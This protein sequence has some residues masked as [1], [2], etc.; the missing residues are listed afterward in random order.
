MKQRGF[1]LLEVLVAMLILSIGLVGLAG[2]MMTGSKNNQSAYH[3][4]QASW[5]AYDI[6]DRMRANRPLAQSGGYD[7]G[8][9]ATPTAT[10]TALTDITQWTTQV[11]NALPEGKGA[12][13]RSNGITEITVSW[14][15]S[16]GLGVL[17]IGGFV[18]NAA[19]SVMLRTKL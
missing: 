11:A 8:L 1:T 15:D 19:Q 17:K 3:R 14:N 18:G 5:M 12:I 4:S 7:L 10:G 2:L 13:A 9:G 16:R 6:L